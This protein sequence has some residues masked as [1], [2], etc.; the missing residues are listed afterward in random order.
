[1]ERRKRGTRTHSPR[2][3]LTET[4]EHTGRFTETQIVATFRYAKTLSYMK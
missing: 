3:T 1:M 4:E 2:D